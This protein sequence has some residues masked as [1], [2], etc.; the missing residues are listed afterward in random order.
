MNHAESF[1]GCL[2][3][4]MAYGYRRKVLLDP[5]KRNRRLSWAVGRSSGWQLKN[6]CQGSPL[7]R[8]SEGGGWEFSKFSSGHNV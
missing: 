3:H 2:A 1:S 4:R 8:D 6:P 7:K 5:H